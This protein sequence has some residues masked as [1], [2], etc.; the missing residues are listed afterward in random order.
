MKFMHVNHIAVVTLLIAGFR[1]D[2]M[3][4]LM[5]FIVREII[6]PS[7]ST[8][9]SGKEVQCMLSSLSRNNIPTCHI[10]IGQSV[11]LVNFKYI[12]L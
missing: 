5:V 7:P 9:F 10:T 11:V 1:A 4:L 2:L 12:I 8:S 6:N 3:T